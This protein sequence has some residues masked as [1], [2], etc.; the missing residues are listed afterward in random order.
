MCRMQGLPIGSRLSKWCQ[1]I[2]LACEP[3]E[4][5]GRPI[6]HWS[7]TELADEAIRQGIVESISAGHLRKALKKRLATAS[8]PLLAQ[9]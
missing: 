7:S 9:R 8:E 5:Y 1:I 2:A 6:S 3:P 4:A